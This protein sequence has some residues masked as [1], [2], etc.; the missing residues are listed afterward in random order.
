MHNLQIIIFSAVS[1]VRLTITRIGDDIVT[2]VE[3]NTYF[4]LVSLEW[5]EPAGEKIRID[6]S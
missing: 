1:V 6:Y 5:I 2:L 4:P 3:V